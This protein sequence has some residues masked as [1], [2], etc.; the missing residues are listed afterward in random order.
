MS[1]RTNKNI[2]RL[3]FD[4]VISGGQLG[5]LEEIIAPDAVD[6]SRPDAV[7]P[8]AFRAHVE[9]LRDAVWP[10]RAVIIDA[11]GTDDTVVVRWQ[12]HGVQYGTLFGTAGSG[13]AL[14]RDFV[15]TLTFRESRIVD[16]DVTAA[17]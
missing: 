2:A 13:R 5:L 16:Y 9:G 14:E 17:A 11:S 10:S 15:S 6:R 4:N 12:L 1:A 8:Q 3:L 7:G